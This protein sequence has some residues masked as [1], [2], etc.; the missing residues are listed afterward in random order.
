MSGRRSSLV[1]R[2]GKDIVGGEHRMYGNLNITMMRPR[3]S[4]QSHVSM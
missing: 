1:I 2:E 3:S 4:A